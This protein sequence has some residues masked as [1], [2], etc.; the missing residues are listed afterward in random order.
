[1]EL[2]EK[3]ENLLIENAIGEV[4]DEY[5]INYIK[6]NPSLIPPSADEDIE[7][8]VKRLFSEKNSEIKDKARCIDII[9]GSHVNLG[10]YEKRRLQQI[11][12]ISKKYLHLKEIVSAHG[13]LSGGYTVNYIDHDDSE[14]IIFLEFPLRKHRVRLKSLMGALYIDRRLVPIRSTLEYTI[15]NLL[16]GNTCDDDVDDAINII[17]DF[18]SST[19]YVKNARKLGR[20]T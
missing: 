20:I 6:A 17:I 16:K 10:K 14:H 2:P 13:W 19:S 12:S 15:I 11:Q 4:D 1:M 9:F 18:V 5:L 8:Q 3:L 7:L